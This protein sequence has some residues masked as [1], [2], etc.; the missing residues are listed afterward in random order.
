MGVFHVSSTRCCGIY[1]IAD[2]SQLEGPAEVVKRSLEKMASYTGVFTSCPA[3]LYFSGVVGKRVRVYS[4]TYHADRSDNYGQALADYI[5]EQGLGTVTAVPPAKN[6]NGNMLGVWFWAPKW[7]V[8]KALHKAY[9]ASKQP[10]PL[11]VQPPT[12]DSLAAVATASN[13]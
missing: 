5:V 3:F 4:T 7:E 1:E 9:E 11:T 2:I 13:Q 12:E 10:S 8:L 6:H